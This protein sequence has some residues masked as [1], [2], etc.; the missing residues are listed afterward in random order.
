MKKFSR[1]E[2][3]KLFNINKETLRYY[4]DVGLLKPIINSQNGYS[5]YTIEDAF[6]LS[7]I[8]RARYLGTSI[9]NLKKLMDSENIYFYDD[10]ITEQLEK[11]KIEIA[12]LTELEKIINRNKAIIFDL[13][14]FENNF[15]F[16]FNNFK[17]EKVSKTLYKFNIEETLKQSREFKDFFDISE[18]EKI[19][20]EINLNNSSLFSDIDYL[21]LEPTK[22]NFD[23]I[24][25][26]I[27]NNLKFEIID[28]SGF[29]IK[30]KFLGTSIELR[31]Y[32]KKLL[33]YYNKNNNLLLIN[34][35]ISIP[36]KN[37]TKYFV[38]IF[39]K[40]S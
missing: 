29:M 15:N 7:T 30:V 3:S 23:F 1:G 31:N 24:N 33:N 34:K 2:L 5:E 28:F 8:L 19:F 22:D 21:F 9:T 27:K 18:K 38:E 6:L 40:L 11:I 4:S 13:K 32:S 26:L 36:N 12:H 39:L 37:G 14:H 10:F 17:K 16:N 25:Y 20:M 35:L